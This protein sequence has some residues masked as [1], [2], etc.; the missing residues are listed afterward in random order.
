M[1][2]IPVATAA[3]A[4]LLLAAC[5]H[6]GDSTIPTNRSLSSS[7]A[8]TTMSAKEAS[9][10]EEQA[11][12]AKMWRASKHPGFLA[13]AA[14]AQTWPDGIVE[15]GQAPLPG[16]LY[17]ITNQYHQR[18][19]ARDIVVYAGSLRE[20]HEAI[21]VTFVRAVD[22]RSVTAPA[23]TRLG[24]VGNARIASAQNGT[25]AIAIGTQRV[26]FSL[27]RAL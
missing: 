8:S 26:P 5:S 15:S 23:V 16:A 1:K 12:H 6:G 7:G 4:A 18:I 11:A 27:T 19:G 9:M 22:G 3:V 25:L 21:V 10:V 13:D 20:T 17:E 24:T 14:S 2:R